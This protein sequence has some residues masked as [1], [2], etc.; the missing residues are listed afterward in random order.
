MAKLIDVNGLRAV[1]AKINGDTKALKALIDAKA[2]AT[3]EHVAADVKFDDGKNLVEKLAEIQ[4]GGQVDLS[5]YATQEYVQGQIEALVDGAPEALN[6]LKELSTALGDDANFASTMVQELAKKV[7]KVEGSRLITQEEATKLAGLANYD[8]TDVKGR[9]TALEGINHDDFAKAADLA[10]K[11]DKEDGKVLIAQTELDR[12]A[13]LHNYDDAAL[14][15]RVAVLEAIDH[16]AFLKAEDIAGKADAADLQALA[17]EVGDPA[18]KAA[19][20]VEAKDA[21]GL[22]KY[23]D[24]KVAAAAVEVATVQELEAMYEEVKAGEPQA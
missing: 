18:V 10:N 11:V 7:D 8:D 12:L 13:G 14:A 24:D 1:V 15:G 17:A 3:H 2:N 20:G 9:L 4:T 16:D 19:E 23:V 5:G 22:Y 21:T 6:A